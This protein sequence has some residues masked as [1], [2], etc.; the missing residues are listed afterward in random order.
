MPGGLHGGQSVA[1]LDLSALFARFKA[2]PGISLNVSG[3]D[4]YISSAAAPVTP[5]K[6]TGTANDTADTLVMAHPLGL[7]ELV[8]STN[9]GPFVPMSSLTINVGDVA[10]PA[11]YYRVKVKAAAG[12][13]ESDVYSS[14]AFSVYV[15]PNARP[16][17][18]SFSVDH[19]AV[20]A[21]Q[22]V[23]FSGA[24]TDSDGSVNSLRVYEGG[25]LIKSI[26]G[27]SG[28]VTSDPL[29]AG[30]HTYNLRAV[31]N[32]NQEGDPFGTTVTV[33]VKAVYGRTMNGPSDEQAGVTLTSEAGVVVK[34]DELGTG[35]SLPMSAP[36]LRNGSQIGTLDFLS[37]YAGQPVEVTYNGI[38][39]TAA[40][41]NGALNI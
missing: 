19:T 4:L 27:A 6:P 14:P 10:R 8:L 20:D 9:S 15:A 33:N 7:S 36:L 5:D 31:D 26:N 37:R 41:A 1:I 39:T 24:G 17:V 23:T 29:T 35:A 21:G 3:G 22:T 25:T 28:S 38:T 30:T 13:N 18:T 32:Q 12:R 34:F 40:F 11:G 16:V 2:G